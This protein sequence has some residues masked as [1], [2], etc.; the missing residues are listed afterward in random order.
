VKPELAAHLE[1]VRKQHLRDLGRGAG[2]K[3][4]TRGLARSVVPGVRQVCLIRGERLAS[5]PRELP[6]PGLAAGVA[7]T[8]G[9]KGR[10]A[11]CVRGEVLNCRIQSWAGRLPVT[12]PPST[13]RVFA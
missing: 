1:R 6:G 2:H 12:E 5:R 8:C 11:R 7:S 13:R 10:P 3:D 4:V 9:R